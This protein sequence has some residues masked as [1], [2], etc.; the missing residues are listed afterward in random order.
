MCFPFFLTVLFFLTLNFNYKSLY[1][2]SSKEKHATT[3]ETPQASAPPPE[4]T[5]KGVDSKDVITIA[6]S[7]SDARAVIEKQVLSSVEQQP[8]KALSWVIYN[9]DRQTCITVS[10]RPMQAQDQAP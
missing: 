2:P 6:L 7:G 3:V 10:V 8:T 4:C 9:L 5:I 1:I